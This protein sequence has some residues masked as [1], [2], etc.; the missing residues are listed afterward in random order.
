MSRRLKIIS[1]L[2]CIRFK[3]FQITDLGF[4]FEFDLQV[5]AFRLP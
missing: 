1:D 3:I 5:L 2:R 4:V